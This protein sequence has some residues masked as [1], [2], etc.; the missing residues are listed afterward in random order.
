MSPFDPRSSFPVCPGRF[1]G[2]GKPLRSRYTLIPS[3]AAVTWADEGTPWLVVNLEE[4]AYNV[5][6]SDYIRAQGP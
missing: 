3:P 1:S 4:V 6:V 5:D 2:L